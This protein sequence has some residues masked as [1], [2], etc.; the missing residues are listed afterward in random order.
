LRYFITE[1]IYERF[2]LKRDSARKDA[3]E[4]RKGKKGEKCEAG[5]HERKKILISF[6]FPFPHVMYNVGCKHD[7]CLNY[8]NPHSGTIWVC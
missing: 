2:K 1:H 5:G 3:G 6:K 4:N 7:Y 8:T